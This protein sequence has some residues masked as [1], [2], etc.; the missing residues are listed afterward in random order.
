M[1]AVIATGGKQQRVEAGT[2]LDVERL[3][4]PVGGE[5]TFNPVLVVSGEQVLATAAD[6]DGTSVVAKVLGDAK[7]PK[8]SGFKY[9]NATTYRRRWGHRQSYTTIEVTHIDGVTEPDDRPEPT[10]QE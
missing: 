1:Y 10:E 3:D 9:K 8:I 2:V 7:G 6:L 4:A 5:V